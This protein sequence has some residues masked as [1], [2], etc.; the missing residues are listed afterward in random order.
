MNGL[1]QKRRYIEQQ[2]RRSYSRY[3]NIGC[4]AAITVT[5]DMVPASFARQEVNKCGKL[6]NLGAAVSELSADT[7]F[8][9][10]ENLTS[11]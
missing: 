11:R 10:R 8:L 3:V 6:R 1:P 7:T 9:M 5:S 2:S 4:L